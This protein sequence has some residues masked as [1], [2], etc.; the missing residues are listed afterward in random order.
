M[1]K[2][3]DF[4]N[5]KNTYIA[6]LEKLYNVNPRMF[7]GLIHSLITPDYSV[8]FLDFSHKT[9]CVHLPDREKIYPATVWHPYYE[10]FILDDPKVLSNVQMLKK[11]IDLIT[12]EGHFPQIL[13]I[14]TSDK[15]RHKIQQRIEPILLK[16]TDDITYNI[17]IITNHEFNKT[18]NGL[19]QI[20]INDTLCQMNR[21]LNDN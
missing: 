13:I 14:T 15:M 5:T 8:G 17:A 16:K 6:K 7:Y 11:H 12:S 9:E 1:R 18:Y 20:A 4:D 2:T 10:L 3:L 19:K 21:L